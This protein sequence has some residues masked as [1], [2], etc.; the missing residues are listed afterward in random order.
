MLEILLVAAMTLPNTTNPQISR[1]FWGLL[2][3]AGELAVYNGVSE[4]V[5]RAVDTHG[6]HATGCGRTGNA[7]HRRTP[8]GN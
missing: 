2:E 6:P 1:G 5:A 7:L 3:M 8:S 4:G